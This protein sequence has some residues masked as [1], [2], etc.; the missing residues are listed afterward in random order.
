[1]RLSPRHA[2]LRERGTRAQ[3]MSMRLLIALGEIYEADR[4]IPIAS[5][6]I[7][8]ASY[9]MVGDPGLEFIEDFAKDANVVVPSTVNPL[10]MDLDRWRE[11]GIPQA[12]A[13]KQ[14]RIADAYR[15]MGVLPSFS[16]T[17]YLI[18][19]RPRRGEHVAW[20]ESSAACFANSVLGARTNREGGPSALASAVT[21]ITP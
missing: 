5:A 3:R 13:A 21:G 9:K 16:C 12:F 1:M 8:G 6:H 15:R 11:Q 4:L 14:R 17:P 2:A 19:L 18:G 20:A 7:A 10:G